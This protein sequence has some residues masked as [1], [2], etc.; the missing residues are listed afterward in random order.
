ME[1]VFVAV[2]K[3]GDMQVSSP[4]LTDSR[5]MNADGQ[6]FVMAHRRP[7]LNAGRAR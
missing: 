5:E 2:E 1:Q 3:I 7:R 4:Q 6:P